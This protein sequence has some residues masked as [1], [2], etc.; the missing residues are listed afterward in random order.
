MRAQKSEIVEIKSPLTVE[1]VL[2]QEWIPAWPLSSGNAGVRWFERFNA[3][4]DSVDVESSTVR[5]RVKHTFGNL[6]LVT[7]PLNASVS[8]AGYEL[9]RNELLNSS[10]LALNRYF[11]DVLVWNEDEIRARGRT[12]FAIAREIWPHGR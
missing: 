6:T 10:A 1:H 8:N 3:S 5:D 7:Q 12:L 11:Q 4:A 9:K 2:P